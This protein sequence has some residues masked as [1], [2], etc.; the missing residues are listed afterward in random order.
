MDNVQQCMDAIMKYFFSFCIR[1]GTLS[2]FDAQSSSATSC[3]PR[4]HDSDVHAIDFFDELT[5][6]GSRN[7][8]VK[9]SKKVHFKKYISSLHNEDIKVLRYVLSEEY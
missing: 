3:L 5:V 2:Y 7:G 1:D 8:D 9:V 4:I 6:S